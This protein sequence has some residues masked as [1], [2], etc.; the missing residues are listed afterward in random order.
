MSFAATLFAAL[1]AIGQGGLSSPPRATPIYGGTKAEPCEWPAVVALDARCSGVLI[2]PEHVLTAAH[3]FPAPEFALFG[4]RIDTPARR[5]PIDSCEA[6]AGGEPGQGN[7][8]MLCTLEEP[9]LIPA[10]PTLTPDEYVL[11]EMGAPVF[12]VGFGQS[13][14]GSTGI[15]RVAKVSLGEENDQGE[16]QL[17]GGGIDSCNG[18][19]GG[20]AFAWIE[21]HGWRVVGITSYG[22]ECGEGGWYAQPHRHHA[23]LEEHAQTEL[24]SFPVVEETSQWDEACLPA[25]FLD[26]DPCTYNNEANR[27][28]AIGSRGEGGPSSLW[29][30]AV[31][32]IA[33]R[34][35]LR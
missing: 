2:S 10:I 25:E 23:W 31:F 15:K 21:G 13:E 5:V 14:D 18:D 27:G 34:K 6:L 9:Q 8:L 33:T 12:V 3:C 4:E 32:L 26:A 17:G 1:F 16:R 19:S 22:F 28:C 30:L 24:C 20:P 11:L 7:D 29:A 35:R